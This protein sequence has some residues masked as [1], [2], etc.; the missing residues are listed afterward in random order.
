MELLEPNRNPSTLHDV[1]QSFAFSVSAL[2]PLDTIFAISSP[3]Q[4]F[5]V[6]ENRYGESSTLQAS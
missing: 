6:K 2:F 1:A 3:T 5:N 4:L